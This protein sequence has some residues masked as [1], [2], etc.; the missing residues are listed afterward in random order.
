MVDHGKPWQTTYYI[1]LSNSHL[2][3]PKCRCCFSNHTMPRHAMN[4]ATVICSP[5]LLCEAFAPTTWLRLETSGGTWHT[6]IRYIRFKMLQICQ[7]LCP[8][9]WYFD[10]FWV[11]KTEPRPLGPPAIE[12]LTLDLLTFRGVPLMHLPMASSFSELACHLCEI[13]SCNFR[14]AKPLRSSL[15]IR[16]GIHDARKA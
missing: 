1:L 11:M 6:S 10:V 3:K 2:L 14:P 4:K 8:N 13:Q 5:R 15:A 12:H 7:I 16:R 9:V